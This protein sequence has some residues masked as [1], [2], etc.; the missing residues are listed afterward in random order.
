M[1]GFISSWAAKRIIELQGEACK[2]IVREAIIKSSMDGF[3]IGYEEGYK[4]GQES[5]KSEVSDADV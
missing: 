4:A 2:Q 1:F 5:V 3:L